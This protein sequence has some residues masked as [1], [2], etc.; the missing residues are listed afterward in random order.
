MVQS[1]CQELQLNN[2]CTFERNKFFLQAFLQFQFRAP[3]THLIPTKIK[4][5][6]KWGLQLRLVT[7]SLCFDD[8]TY[9]GTTDNFRFIFSK[10]EKHSLKIKCRK[11]FICLLLR[12]LLLTLGGAELNPVQPSSALSKSE[13]CKR[14]PRKE[15]KIYELGCQDDALCK[16][17]WWD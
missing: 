14:K 6:I 8:I 13:I 3:A 7:R 5:Q 15:L 10:N 17:A 4:I 1:I 2:F 11:C 12:Y 16:A 9:Q